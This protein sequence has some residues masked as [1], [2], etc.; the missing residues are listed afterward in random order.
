VKIKVWKVQGV[1]AL[2]PG[3]DSIDDSIYQDPDR[4]HR[5]I[6]QWL[7]DGHAEEFRIAQEGTTFIIEQE[8]AP[9]E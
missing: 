2:L 7:D 4:A 3:D 8:D 1:L 6:D 9:K 5:V